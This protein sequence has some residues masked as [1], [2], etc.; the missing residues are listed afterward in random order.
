[1]KQTRTKHTRCLIPAII[2]AASIFPVGAT[3]S[4][5]AGSLYFSGDVTLTTD[6]N[7]M[8]PTY[9]DGTLTFDPVMG[10]SYDF[11]VD[12]GTGFFAGLTGGGDA[13][14]FGAANEPV[15]TTPNVNLPFLTFVNS[16]VTFTITNVYPGVDGSGVQRQCRERSEW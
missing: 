1:M 15:S 4:T 12:D 2:A 16:P 6:D 7:S 5:I 11:T 10:Q 14:T 9:G 3:A 8:S 13:A